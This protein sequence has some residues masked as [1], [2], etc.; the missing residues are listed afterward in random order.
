MPSRA[1]LA[2]DIVRVSHA[3]H[4]NGWV[5]NHDGNVSVRLAPGRY[6]VT[7]TA[8]SKLD[9][10][11]G[12]LAVVGD[13]GKPV[14][15]EA[16]PPSEFAL[17]LGA[18]AERPDIG[19]VIHAHPPYATAIACTGKGITTFLA[20]AVVSIGPEVPVTT[21]ALPFGAAGAAPIRA[22]IDRY[23]ALLL[24]RHGVIT[25]GKDLE[26]ALL[27]M[28]LVEHMAK[29]ATLALPH[30]GVQPLPEDV[31]RPLIQKRRGAKLGLAAERTALPGGE[32][33]PAPAAAPTAA[34]S[35]TPAGP[36]PAPDAWSGGKTEG[37]CGVVYGAPGVETPRNE[38]LASA[39]KTAIDRHLAGKNS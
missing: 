11:E 8:T 20:E 37:A 34:S 32:A 24:C 25:V 22:L 10:T 1:E 30:G 12:G 15:G 39:V 28:E 13:D 5:A 18:F 26:T 2:T 17:H 35:W 31:L 4:R 27:R 21:F 19:A 38:E 29:I 16:R 23:D 36:P 14:E 6:L 33:E 9:I 7:P 3:L